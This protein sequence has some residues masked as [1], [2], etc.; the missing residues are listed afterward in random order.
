LSEW[1]HSE[2]GPRIP[3]RHD[4]LLYLGNRVARPLLLEALVGSATPF[5][6]LRDT[7]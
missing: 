1:L 2:P 5:H 4:R 6:D 3:L 7:L